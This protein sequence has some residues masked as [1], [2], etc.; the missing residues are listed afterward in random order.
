MY[1]FFMCATAV[2]QLY[3]N[4]CKG[5]CINANFRLFVRDRL[6]YLLP[7]FIPAYASTV[8]G[9]VDCLEDMLQLFLNLTPRQ[10]GYDYFGTK[11]LTNLGNLDETNYY[12]ES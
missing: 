1:P 2:L 6:H 11:N 5:A 7:H 9:D 8:P 10:K 12:F 3:H 4:N